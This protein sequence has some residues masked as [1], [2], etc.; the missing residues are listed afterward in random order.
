MFQFNSFVLKLR[1]LL[2]YQA[3]NT[4]FNDKTDLYVDSEGQISRIR[5]AVREKATS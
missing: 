5:F 4:D 2:D 3:N 1:T